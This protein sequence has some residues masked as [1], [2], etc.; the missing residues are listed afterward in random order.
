MRYY[1]KVK[2]FAIVEG[3]RLVY[4]FGPRAVGWK[5]VPKH[6]EGKRA[7]PNPKNLQRILIATLYKTS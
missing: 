6:L 1:Y 2:I 4:K 5:P 3:K 7:L